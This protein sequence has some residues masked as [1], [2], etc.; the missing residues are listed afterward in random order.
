MHHI[1]KWHFLLLLFLPFFLKA[2][3][4]N[5]IP[6]VVDSLYREDQVYVSFTY[7]IVSGGPSE[8]K[9]SQ[10]SGGFHTGFIRDFPLNS[11]RN[12]ALGV[13]LGWSL[14]TYGQNL[15][16]GEA[17]EGEGTRFTVLN[18]DRV[19]FDANRF[20]TQSIDLPIQFRWRTSTPESYKFWRIYTGI[21]PAY[22][23]HFQ[24]KFVQDGNSFR[25]TNIPE[26]EKL[27]LGATFTFGYNTFNFSFYYSLNSF[28]KDA[29]VNNEDLDLRTFQVGLT[30]YLL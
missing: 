23:Y 17:T 5:D 1:Q 19:D 3:E 16:I 28:F 2:Q 10:F 27:R 29:A 11:R 22:V 18:R 13:G 12:V 4:K 30:F 15:F 14:D 8:I 24:S 20:T 7:N 9:S 26:F 25:E 21:R 6:A